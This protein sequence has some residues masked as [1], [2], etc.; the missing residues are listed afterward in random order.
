M[1]NNLE[2]K[3]PRGLRLANPCNIRRS[4][5][6]WQG[7]AEEQTDP[8]FFTFTA[9]KWG[10]RAA[11]RTL[12][13]YQRK[14]ACLSVSDFISRWAPSNENN[15][16]SYIATVCK[17]T[18]WTADQVIDVEDEDDM[19]ALAAAMSY[20]ENGVSANLEDIREGWELL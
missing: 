1:G 3:L 4:A 17:R 18:G 16:A 5:D 19:V 9:M 15:T 7:L 11:L 13:T 10:Y 12:Q 14:Y 8:D 20:V 2:K 6:K